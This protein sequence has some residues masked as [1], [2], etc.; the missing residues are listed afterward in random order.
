M[1]FG[2]VGLGW[3][4]R[5]F[6]LPAL[7]QVEGVSVVGGCDSSPDQRASWERETGID[8]FASVEELLE[9]RKPE[10]VLVATPP[11]A[12]ADLCLRVLAGG[13]H[14]I[15]EK[16]FASTLEEA[17][18]VLAAARAAGR[19]VAVNHEFREKP[20]FKALK[21]RIGSPVAGRLVFCQIWQLMD[22]APWDEPVAWRAAM[23]NRTL[24]E[25]GVHLVDLLLTLFGEKPEAVYARHSSGLHRNR[26]ADAIHLVTL[27]FPE[28]RLAQITIDRLCPG[29]TRY[30]EVRADCERASLRASLGGRAL[31]QVGKKRAERT[32]VRFE[33]GSGGLAWMEQG[34]KRTTLARGPRQAGMHATA[35]LLAAIADALREEREP[36][37][38]GREARDGLE[39]IEA[40]YQ[41]AATGERIELAAMP[42]V[43]T[44]SPQSL[45]RFENRNR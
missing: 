36:P 8:A 17:D 26:D 33:F 10:V 16:P 22:L 38:S 24:F 3:A 37:S 34:L 28:N 13:A 35:A 27:E 25:G 39:V 31:V 29:G 9:Q 18:R 1:R 7:K 41:S 44:A 14:V 20:I 42:Q 40:A 5:A 45:D 12:H 2:L 30:V 4:A 23:P 11:D 19:Q 43:G 6:H 15:C 32:G 21:E